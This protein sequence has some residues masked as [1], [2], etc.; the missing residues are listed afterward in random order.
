M[1]VRLCETINNIG[2][3]V[4]NTDIAKFIENQEKDYYSSI[5]LYNEDQK[6]KAEELIEI[7]KDGKTFKRP[8]GVSGIKEVVTNKL[9]F[10][11]DSDNLQNAKLDTRSWSKLSR[12]KY[13]L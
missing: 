6:R 5:F 2:K 3:L 10:D 9:V 11:F 1:Y 12:F 4:P 7:T 13:M 8:K